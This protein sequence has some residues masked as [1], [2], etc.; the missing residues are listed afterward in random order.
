MLCLGW[1]S[2]NATPF[3]MLTEGDPG[4]SG[5]ARLRTFDSLA[6][7]MAL[8]QASST[9]I[10]SDIGGTAVSIGGLTYDGDR[11]LMITEGDPGTSGN[12]WLRTFDTLADLMA[13]NQASATLIG[14]DIGGSA[15]S[16]AGLA[17]DGDDYLMLTEGDPGTSGAARLRT[18]DT[19]ADLMALNQA[20]S[21]LIGSDIGGSAVSIRGLTTAFEPS[22]TIPEPAP[23]TLLIMGLIGLAFAR[24]KRST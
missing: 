7:L 11:Y 20:S 18:F 21:T 16:I 9:L 14:S 19:L 1:G 3:Y 8:N 17:F 12:A 5:A 15:V 2:A 13:L 10:G 6:D 23:V 4:T 22:G 24:R